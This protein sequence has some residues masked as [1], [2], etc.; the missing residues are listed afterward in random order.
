MTKIVLKPE[1]DQILRAEGDRIMAL[2]QRVG[3]MSEPILTTARRI[4]AACLTNGLWVRSWKFGDVSD[5]SRLRSTIEATKRSGVV[6]WRRSVAQIT[7]MLTSA[8]DR[9][10]AISQTVDQRF[11]LTELGEQK[12]VAPGV[13]DIMRREKKKAIR[14]ELREDLFDGTS[15]E[16][17]LQI[18]RALGR[19]RHVALIEG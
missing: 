11:H 14:W 18:V 6:D 7:I 5:E 15:L 3:A 13:D 1:S 9:H 2:G 16:D 8:D 4:L 19:A 17:L 12:E 10:F